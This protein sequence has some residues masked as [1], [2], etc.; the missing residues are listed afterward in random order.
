MLVGPLH[1]NRQTKQATTSMGTKL[2]I[3]QKEFD[4]LEILAEQEGETV[5]FER[6]G[7]EQPKLEHLIG[8]VECAG[9]GFMWIEHR[10]GE[11]YTFHTKWADSL[12]PLS[13]VR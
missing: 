10:P 1:L 9:Q 6:L 3:D 5:S 7:T 2:Y 12:K 8:Q 11:G 13:K 4:A